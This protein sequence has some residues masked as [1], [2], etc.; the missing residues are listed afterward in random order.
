MH[1]LRDLNGP[2]RDASGPRSLQLDPAPRGRGPQPP[3]RFTG[4]SNLRYNPE[5][6]RH[7]LEPLNGST[8]VNGAMAEGLKRVPNGHA[9]RD[10][11]SL[12]LKQKR[13]MESR[14]SLRKLKSGGNTNYHSNGPTSLQNGHAA[15]SNGHTDPEDKWYMKDSMRPVGASVHGDNC[16]CYRCQRKLTAI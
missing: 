11:N 2:M 16:K 7:S 15:M 3:E 5:T 14:A 9:A 1:P 12:R 13:E 6:G 4:P 8:E 10:R